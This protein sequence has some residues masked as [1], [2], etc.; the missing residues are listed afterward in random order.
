MFSLKK[1]SN[2]K[3]F[4]ASND[5]QST[6][7]LQEKLSLY[8]RAFEAITDLVE[9]TANGN[10]S[11]RIVH[12]DNFGELTPTLSKLNQTLDLADAFVRESSASLQSA[13][14]KEYHRTFMTQGILGDFGNAAEIINS[15][16]VGIKE[17]E[18]ERKEQLQSLS[19]EFEDH[20]LKVIENLSS[21]TSQTN[22]QAQE[23]IKHAEVNKVQAKEVFSASEQTHVNVQ[24]VASA[25]EQLSA[26]IQE[27]T[28]QVTSSF[29]KTKEVANNTTHT[30]NRINELNQSAATIDQVVK[31]ISDIAGQTNLLALNATIEAARAGEAGRGFSVVASEV[32]TL[33]QQTTNATQD[34]EE[35]VTDIQE[36]T[37][38][39]VTAVNEITGS[40]DTLKEI[41]QAISAAVEEQS[42]ATDEISRNINEASNSTNLVFKNMESVRKSAEDTAIGANEVLTAAN[43]IQNEINILKNKSQ[44]FVKSILT[45]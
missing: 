36:K 37:L 29:E 34:I 4:N 20:V 23:L 12:W 1:K 5:D 19:E 28:R 11:E 45:S 24:T 2:A 33:A 10:L 44:E 38:S 18:I 27:I 43:H 30:T 32:K 22:A 17:K 14:R 16:S 8:E 3:N 15:A 9:N 39:S 42:S 6:A 13:M 25:S 31:L 35:Q 40:L 26:S 21:A 7:Q 41:A